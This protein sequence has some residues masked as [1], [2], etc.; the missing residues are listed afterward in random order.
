LLSLSA[1]GR[2]S[3][4][5]IIKDWLF[6]SDPQRLIRRRDKVGRI[7]LPHFREMV[8]QEVYRGKYLCKS[9][10]ATLKVLSIC[11]IRLKDFNNLSEYYLVFIAK[12][13]LGRDPFFFLRI[14]KTK[15]IKYIDNVP[16]S[17]RTMD[18]Q[19]D[20]IPLRIII[21]LDYQAF[22]SV[23]DKPYS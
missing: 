16:K 15:L 13:I 8:L 4:Y 12:N 10:S 1:I 9:K 17:E 14:K 2:C 23:V 22:E 18:Y 19:I 5:N 20:R 6:K 21:C 3:N 7:P 11:K